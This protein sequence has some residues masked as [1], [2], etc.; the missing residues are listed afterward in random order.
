MIRDIEAV[1]DGMSRPMGRVKANKK[2]TTTHTHTHSLWTTEN[3]K[4]NTRQDMF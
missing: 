2:L 1:I 4:H 3:F